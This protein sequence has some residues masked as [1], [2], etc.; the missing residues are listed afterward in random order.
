M[1]LVWKTLHAIVLFT[2]VVT[3]SPL[4]AQQCGPRVRK[5]WDALTPIEKTTYKDAVAAAMDSGAYIKFVQI[6]TEMLSER[7]AHR[8]CMFIYWHRLLLVVFENMLRGQGARFACVTVPYYNWIRAH[9]GAVAGSCSSLGTC[10]SIMSELGGYDSGLLRTITINGKEISGRCAQDAPLNHFCPSDTNNST[11]P[12]CAHCVPRGNWGQTSVAA[13]LS[14]ASVRDQLFRG[15]TIGQMSPLIEQGCHNTVHGSLSGTMSSFTATADPLFYSH[16]AAVD[17]LHTIFHKCRVG[18]HRL[19]FQEK[20]THPVAWSSC[21]KRGG[22]TFRPTDAIVMRTG[23]QGTNPIPANEDPILGQYFTGVPNQYAGLM[24]VRDLGDSSYSY[25]LSGQLADMYT[26]CDGTS[27]PPP[28]SPSAGPPEAPGP[29]PVPAPSSSPRTREQ[30]SGLDP[31]GVGN[32]RLRAAHGWLWSWFP[33]IRFGDADCDDKEEHGAARPSAPV[34][35]PSPSNGS[36]PYDSNT[37]SHKHVDVILATTK[38]SP[39]EVKVST[40]YDE[41]VT[42]M[43]GHGPDVM[44]DLERQMCMF[45][46]ECLGGTFDYT[47]DF[48]ATWSVKEPRCLT[49]VHA[50]Q[51]GKAKIAYG[52]WRERME[53]YFGCPKPANATHGVDATNAYASVTQSVDQT[54]S[55]LPSTDYVVESGA[56]G[57]VT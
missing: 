31:L 22:G 55:V 45:E 49:L 51:S 34:P 39:E 57:R 7:Q 10:S 50:M 20:A 13:S 6:H 56:S 12:L 44:A 32:R 3:L 52:A 26:N 35:S 18:T 19:T 9:A 17:A 8:Q 27:P 30:P 28:S 25:E 54:L 46:Q 48:K 40:W 15:Q 43:G 38:A 42:A 2:V 53:S 14:Y 37:N 1:H 33:S 5:D 11:A 4:H 23:V 41:T 47:D 36:T 16:H 21:P 24:D 29:A